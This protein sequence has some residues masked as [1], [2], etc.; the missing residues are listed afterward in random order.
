[1]NDDPDTHEEG[2]P[3]LTG[4]HAHEVVHVASIVAGMFERHL[5]DHRF[6]QAQPALKAEAERI[7][8][9]LYDFYQ[10]CGSVACG[11]GEAAGKDDRG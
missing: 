5:L 11:F 8:G 9:A 2:P 10:Q 1:M 4:F 3:E 7:G 6:V